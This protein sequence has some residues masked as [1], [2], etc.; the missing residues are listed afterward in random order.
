MIIHT[1]N[2]KKKIIPFV[3]AR[4]WARQWA[5]HYG[6]K[7]KQ[8]WINAYDEMIIIRPQ[9]LMHKINNNISINDAYIVY[10]YYYVNLYTCMQFALGF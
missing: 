10:K 1:M 4:Q 5:K 3:Q 8:D 7:S 6:I 9:K 2:S